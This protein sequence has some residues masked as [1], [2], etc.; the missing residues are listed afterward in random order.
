MQIVLVAAVS[1]NGVIGRKGGLPWH[2]AADLRHVRRLTW[3]HP[4]VMGRRTFESLPR[5]PLP[6]RA[7]LVLT[8]QQAYAAP[9]GVLVCSSLE[10]A[11]ALAREQGATRLS[12]LGGAQVYR[13]ALPLCD[14]MILTHV[15]LSVEGDTFFPAWDRQDWDAVDTRSEAGLSFVT[16]RRAPRRR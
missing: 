9:A 8:R 5:R 12:V 2:Y 3:G 14:L 1:R 13:E 10:E 4:V 7:N 15:P 6:G 16:Y 11:V